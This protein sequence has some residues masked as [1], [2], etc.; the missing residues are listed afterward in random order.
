MCNYG[1]ER[2]F[3]LVIQ[4]PPWLSGQSELALTDRNMHANKCLKVVLNFCDCPFF[5]TV[6]QSINPASIESSRKIKQ[7]LDKK[8]D[9]IFEIRVANIQSYVIK[10]AP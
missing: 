6:G 2:L 5:G 4:G 10:S 3:S 9:F 1:A 7:N 8:L